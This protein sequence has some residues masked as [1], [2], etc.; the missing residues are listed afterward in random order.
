MSYPRMQRRRRAA[1][2]AASLAA[3][4]AANAGRCA[5]PAAPGGERPDDDSAKGE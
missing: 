4:V 2:W 1:D 5:G 3:A